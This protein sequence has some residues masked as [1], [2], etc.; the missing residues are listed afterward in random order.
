MNNPLLPGYY[1]KLPALGDFVTRRLPKQFVGPWDQWLQSAMLA[2]R[3]LLGEKWLDVYL[4]SPIWRFGLSPGICGESAWAG[5]LMPS[6]DKVGR[7]YPL[8]LAAPLGDTESLEHLFGPGG[9]QWFEELEQL[10]L[11]CLEDSLSLEA[12]DERLQA[13][14]APRFVPQASAL[15]VRDGKDK[16]GKFACHVGMKTLEQ[17]PDAFVDLSAGLMDRFMPMR[18]LWGTSGSVRIGASLLACEGLPP[19]DAF[20]ALLTGEWSQRGWALISRGVRVFSGPQQLELPDA[21][22][23]GS[24]PSA[25][26]PVFDD[27]DQPTTRPRPPSPAWNWRS[28]GI[29]VV[30]NRRTL[31]EDNLIERADAGLWAVADGMGGHKAGD[32]ASQ[33]IVDALGKLAQGYSLSAFADNVGQCLQEVNAKLCRLAEQDIG[34]GQIIGSTVVVLLASG[35]RCIYQWAGDSRLY[36]YREGKL[37]QLTRD[38]SL[39]DDLQ[40]QGLLSPEQLADPGRCDIITRAVGAAETLQLD[41]GECEA[42]PGDLYLLCSDGLDKEL[43]REEIETVFRGNPTE[44]IASILIAQAEERGARDNVTVVVVEPQP[45]AL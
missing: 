4:T 26:D 11:S 19:I 14:P 23:A 28:W 37:E 17:T 36:R 20:A 25:V 38:H 21:V 29:S 42:M 30:G 8:T 32:V 12:F 3:E 15:E 39:L 16:A 9:N 44:N 27:D 24:A 45:M 1:G 13:N 2:S 43:N 18:T 10:A 5:V 33:N 7:Y 41:R 31:N 35:N 22:S 6:V 34:E 40:A